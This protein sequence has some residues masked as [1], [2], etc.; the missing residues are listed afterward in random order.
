MLSNDSTFFFYSNPAERVPVVSIL[1]GQNWGVWGIDERTGYTRKTQTGKRPAITQAVCFCSLCDPLYMLLPFCCWQLNRW[2]N[3]VTAQQTLLKLLL[4]A[5]PKTRNIILTVKNVSAAGHWTI[6]FCLL[7]DWS[8][9]SLPNRGVYWSTKFWSYL[10]GVINTIL[11]NQ[12][13][14]G[15]CPIGIGN[16][17][18]SLCH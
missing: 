11:V 2:W 4:S 1:G 14:P 9:I 8:T 5:H 6:V 18:I 10:R 16:H 13:E 17:L 7:G 15:E 12:R 3:K